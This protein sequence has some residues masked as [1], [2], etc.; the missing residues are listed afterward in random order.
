MDGE[1][2]LVARQRVAS[3]RV[4]ATFVE[5]RLQLYGMV[6][7]VL[8]VLCKHRQKHRCQ[9]RWKNTGTSGLFFQEPLS[10]SI[11]FKAKWMKKKHWCTC[12]SE[13]ILMFPDTGRTVRITVSLPFYCN[14]FTQKV[15][16]CMTCL[17]ASFVVSAH[18][19]KHTSSEKQ[20]PVS[21]WILTSC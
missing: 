1:L 9:C 6:A 18:S 5:H 12:A 21:Y 20:K 4:G 13:V 8:H 17:P 10:D 7:Q 11:L 19:G 2:Y 15:W 14:N 16:S 3:V